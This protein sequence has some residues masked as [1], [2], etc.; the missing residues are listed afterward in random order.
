MGAGDV[1]QVLQALPRQLDADVPGFVGGRRSGL[2]P[3]GAAREPP[4]G[5]RLRRQLDLVGEFGEVHAR[6]E[7]DPGDVDRGIQ[8][9]EGVLGARHVA[10]GAEVA[11][12]LRLEHVGTE[13]HGQPARLDDP[14]D[15][16]LLPR[17]RRGVLPGE[18]MPDGLDHEGHRPVGG[19]LRQRGDQIALLRGVRGLGAVEPQELRDVGPGELRLADA[20]RLAHPRGALGGVA[21]V[22]VVLEADHDADVA[23]DGIRQHRL[24]VGVLRVD[25]EAAHRFAQAGDHPVLPLDRLFVRDLRG[26][27]VDEDLEVG[28][29]VDRA[30]RE[31]PVGG[32]RPAQRSD[33]A[34]VVGQRSRGGVRHGGTFF[35]WV[36]CRGRGRDQRGA[37]ASSIPATNVSPRRAS[38]GARACTERAPR[39]GGSADPATRG[40]ATPGG[41]RGRSRPA[42]RA[43]ARGL[44]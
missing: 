13:L 32:R 28:E 3:D 29:V 33:L 12:E 30:Q 19:L 24:G 10:T 42:S 37:S 26:V 20:P 31:E 9:R 40:V 18:R 38:R 5:A 17:R 25:E 27:V 8:L 34:H 22:A 44:R 15:A 11:R 41:S 43:A 35:S 7:D 2:A 36:V 23:P 21:E 16:R 4:A 1:R 6:R 14:V 39:R